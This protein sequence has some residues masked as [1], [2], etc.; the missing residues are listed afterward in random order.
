MAYAV[1]GLTI[2]WLIRAGDTNSATTKGQTRI[3]N[4]KWQY[5]LTAWLSVSVIALSPF[6]ASDRSM[7]LLVIVATFAI[8]TIAAVSGSVVVSEL[9]VTKRFLWF[10]QSFSLTDIKEIQFNEQ[11]R[12]IRLRSG[13]R[14]LTINSRFPIRTILDDIVRQTGVAPTITSKA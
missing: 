1:M 7:I 5:R 4:V 10:S 3:Y 8:M 14:R 12:R 11:R 9:G 13:S 2:G 6:A